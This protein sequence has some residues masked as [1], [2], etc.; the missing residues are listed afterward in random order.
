MMS[1]PV[2][3][4]PIKRRILKNTRYLRIFNLQN[5]GPAAALIF[6]RRIGRAKRNQGLFPDHAVK[7]DSTTAISPGASP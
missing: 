4:S 5:S 3:K 7:P 1:T 2:E 6:G